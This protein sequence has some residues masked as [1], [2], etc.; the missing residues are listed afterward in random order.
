MAVRLIKQT[1]EEGADDWL[2]CKQASTDQE[3]PKRKRRTHHET[4]DAADNAKRTSKRRERV[5]M[6]HQEHEDATNSHEQILHEAHYTKGA[7]HTQQE[8]IKK[9]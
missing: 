7:K 9:V 6:Q 8:C 4:D 1:H 3:R 2:D 5:D